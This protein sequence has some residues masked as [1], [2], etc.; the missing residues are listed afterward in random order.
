MA[1]EETTVRTVIEVLHDGENGFRS[2]GEKLQS[3]KIKTFFLEESSTRGRFAAELE[4]AL[5]AV[6][7]KDISEGG[8]ASGTLHRAWGELKSKLGA[9]D[10]A[11]LDTAEQGEDAA[12]KA[13]EVA[14]NKAD[15]PANIHTL[16]QKQQT[17]ILSSHDKVKVLRDATAA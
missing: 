14:L 5:S 16:L 4:E 17:H 10:H 7:G 9:G 1:F 11:L 15:V 3:A 12:K 2:L 8:T 6:K 13:Y